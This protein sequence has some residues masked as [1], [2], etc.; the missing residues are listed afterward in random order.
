[1]QTENKATYG[2][3]RPPLWPAATGSCGDEREKRR[4][5]EG[6]EERGEWERGGWWW[7][8]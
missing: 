8:W 7:S 6:R 5:R 2:R 1:M 4:E 3:H